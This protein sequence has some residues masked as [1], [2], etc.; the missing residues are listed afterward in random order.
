[1]IAV[2]GEC[3][4]DLLPDGPGRY[5]ARPGG[6]PANTAVAAVR[7]G[8][9]TL[10]LA[11]L[12]RDELGQ[13]LRRHLRENGVDLSWAVTTDDPSGVAVVTRDSAGS[14]SYRF[15][16]DGAADWQWSDA[17]LPELPEAVVAVHAGSLAL[18]LPPGAAALEAM[19]AR[20]RPRR[21]ISI[22]PNLRPTLLGSLAEAV[23]RMERWLGVADVV[24]ASTDDLELL[25]PGTDPAVVAQRWSAAGP[26]VVVVTAGADGVLAMVHGELLRL[27]AVPVH[28][29]DTV[30]AGDT[31]SGALLHALATSGVLGGRLDAVDPDLIRRAL[32]YAARAAAVTCSRVG[33]DPPRA[34][35]VPGEA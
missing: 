22:D 34:D 2:C 9:P 13:L 19:L 16:L 4:V 26:A 24:K 6:S 29:V 20:E 14:A 30:G 17:E 35:E 18:A 15:A 27:P 31:Y 1:M 28:V 23:A 21:T 25:Y 8:T 10:L 11:R 32:D 12:S 3:L 7:L 5:V 33:A